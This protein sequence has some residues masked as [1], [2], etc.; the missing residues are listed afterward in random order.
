MS[1]EEHTNIFLTDF[2][3]TEAK[4][5]LQIIEFEKVS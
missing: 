5:R 1:Y 3:G 4:C 2:H